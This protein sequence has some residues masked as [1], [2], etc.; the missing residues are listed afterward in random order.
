MT[1]CLYQWQPHGG[2]ARGRRAFT[3]GNLNVA[4]VDTVGVWVG[5]GSVVVGMSVLLLLCGC[6]VVL[7]GC[8]GAPGVGAV[9]WVQ[10]RK[11]GKT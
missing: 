9:W 2:Y 8:G 1:P 11:M 6:G 5:G 4:V 10:K 3:A 7:C